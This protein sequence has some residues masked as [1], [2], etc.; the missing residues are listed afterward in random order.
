MDHWVKTDRAKD[1]SINYTTNFSQLN[2]KNRDLFDLWKH[3]KNVSIH[4]SLDGSWERGEY[5]R[6]GLNWEKVIANR[7]LMLEHCPDIQFE[8]T[9]TVSILNVLNLAD[10]HREWLEQGLLSEPNLF[11]FNWLF[12]PEEF[13]IQNLPYEYKNLVVDKWKEHKQWLIS[14]YDPNQ[15]QNILSWI[16]G[17]VEY[18]HEDYNE[19][20]KLIET[21]E[22]YDVIRNESWRTIFPELDK[23][24]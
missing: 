22:K 2:Y 17:L 20:N 1:I 23:V 14:N 10:F 8:I 5:I 21:L 11:R 6:K 24:L 7:K 18:I 4:A 15:L 19:N 3:F 16:D 9:P 13:C 12:Y